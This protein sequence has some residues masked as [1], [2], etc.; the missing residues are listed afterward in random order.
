MLEYLIALLLTLFVGYIVIYS[1]IKGMKVDLHINIIQKFS[2]EDRK[3]LE[4]I[5]NSDGDP[6]KIDK[7]APDIDRIVTE[8]NKI[9]LGEEESIDG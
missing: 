1:L 7:D 8:V 4:D 9:M 2:E 3:L 6:L 5:Y